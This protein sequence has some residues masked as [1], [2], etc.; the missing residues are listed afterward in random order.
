M[1]SS[2]ATDPEALRERVHAALRGVQDPEMGESIVDLGLVGA[3]QVLD[4]ADQPEGPG[5]LVVLIPTSATC[6]MAD[7][8]LQDTVDATQ[9][10]L[11]P[12]WLADATLD[13]DTPW[14]PARMSPALQRQFG[15]QPGSGA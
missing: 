15:W 1:T 11:P 13:F 12:G 10:V 7:M 9:A 3:V 6:P 14:S 4:G 5:V 2:T 8:L